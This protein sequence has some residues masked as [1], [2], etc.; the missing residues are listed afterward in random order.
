LN[1]D[2]DIISINDGKT[3]PIAAKLYDTIT[4]IQYGRLEDKYDW[5]CGIDGIE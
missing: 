1:Y 5:I 4:G 3:G 2:G